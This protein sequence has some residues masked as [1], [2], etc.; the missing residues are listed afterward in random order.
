[1]ALRRLAELG[2]RDALHNLAVAYNTG[3]GVAKDLVEA[4]KLF[5]DLL[6]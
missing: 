5:K 2:D 4:F 6:N 1:M 3:M